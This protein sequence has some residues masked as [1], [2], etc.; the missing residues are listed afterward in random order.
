MVK[1]KQK[2]LSNS[3]MT[4]FAKPMTNLWLTVMSNPF[5]SDEIKTSVSKMKMNQSPGCNEIPVELMMYAPGSVY[6]STA[7][8]FNQIA[9]NGDCPKEIN[10]GIL[11]PLE[12]PGK[13]RGSASNF[14]P[15]ILSSTLR[16]I[17]SVCIM[18]QVGSRLDHE[19][20]ITQA[21]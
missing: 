3:S 13:S 2:S 12:K 8:I 14:W 10:H 19:T 20:P 18:D 9:S 7:E 21:A 11:V 17:L 5:T 1:Y 15:I 4:Y 6:E 16:K